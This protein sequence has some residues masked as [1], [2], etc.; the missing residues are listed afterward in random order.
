MKVLVCGY[1][2]FEN[3]G[4]ELILDLLL[5]DLRSMDSEV[6]I[7]VVSGA[8]ESVRRR[9]S[10][11]AIHLSDAE[12]TIRAAVNADLMVLGGGGIFQDY[13][14][15]DPKTVLLASQGGIA[16]YSGFAI[17]GGLVG[18][19]VAIYAVGIGPI[20][21]DQGRYLTAL[22]FAAASS[23]TVRDETSRLLLE[24]M[25]VD[26]A[27]IIVTAD[28]VFALNPARSDAAA[29][30]NVI[31]V[32]VRP[33]GGGGWL[34]PLTEALARLAHTDHAAL[35]LIP[36]QSSERAHEDDVNVASDIARRLASE[37]T[38]EVEPATCDPERLLKTIQGC[39]VVV[40][41]RLHAVIMAA[42]CGT[43]VV[44]L[45]YDNKVA[46]QMR[47]LGMSALTLE[48]DGVTADDIQ[49][50]VR[51]ALD[52]HDVIRDQLVSSSADTRRR[53]TENRIAL[54]RALDLAKPRTETQ[55]FLSALV[56]DRARTHRLMG[57]N[58]ARLEALERE[59][60]QLAGSKAVRLAAKWWTIRR[61]VRQALKA[62]PNR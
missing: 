32:A 29:R 50:R 37:V 26:S 21:T 25:G 30:T 4:D 47:D 42:T 31:G 6:E 19:P 11:D 35:R 53:V 36:M 7:T 62:E 27:G 18:T 48:L 56:E 60:A 51:Q 28:P 15:T 57:N 13:D 45:A 2:G 3:A 43:P 39:D 55:R 14:T 41:M 54:V 52:H 34:D 38:V 16:H 58:Q 24:D 9:P 17:L 8:P 44:A 59:Y 20:T 10:I 1:Y 12:A 22:A 23:A 5:E 46:T 61:W 33:W 40:A 49:A